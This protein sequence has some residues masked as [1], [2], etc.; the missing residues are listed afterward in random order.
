MRTAKEVLFESILNYSIEHGVPEEIAE[1]ITE[2]IANNA[3]YQEALK[4]YAKE[5]LEQVVKELPEPPLPQEQY[6]TIIDALNKTV[7]K[8]S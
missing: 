7:D 6:D 2:G 4:T 1:S 3:A 8:L 5:A